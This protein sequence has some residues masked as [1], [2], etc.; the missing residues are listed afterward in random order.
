MSTALLFP[1]QGAQKVGMG[2]DL[3]EAFPVARETFAIADRVLGFPLSRLAFE[4]P[5]DELTSTENAQ[6]AIYTASVAALRVLQEH[7][8]RADVALGH[9]IGEYAALVCAGALEFEAGLALV[10]RR[11][12]LMAECARNVGGTMAAVVGLEDDAVRELAARIAA[13]RV[14]RASLFNAPG[15]VVVSGE[16]EAVDDLCAAAKAVGAKRT[17][18]LEVSGAW[19]TPLMQGAADRFAPVLDAAPIADPVV[20]VIANVSAQPVTTAAEVRGALKAQIVGAVLWGPSLALLSG[21]GVTRGIEAGADVVAGM[22]RRAAPDV[23]A[24]SV[25]DSASLAKVLQSLGRDGDS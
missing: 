11:G 10:R 21:L 12:E 18:G 25:Y 22:L 17:I 7:G 15:Q 3:A 5:Q 1:G 13:G 4:G 6:P 20:P 9:S 2:R 23:A 8:V 14:L 19:H 24:Y 16:A